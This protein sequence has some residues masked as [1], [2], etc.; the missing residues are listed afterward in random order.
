MVQCLEKH[1]ARHL[2][3]DLVFHLE[4]SWAQEWVHSWGP[5]TE[6]HWGKHLDCR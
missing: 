6:K 2:G 5:L 1:W 4:K 3:S